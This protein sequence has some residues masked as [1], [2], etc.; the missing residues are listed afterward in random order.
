LII[1]REMV[2]RW[3]WSGVAVWSGGEFVELLGNSDAA[4]GI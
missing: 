4:R 3:S 2:R 1:R